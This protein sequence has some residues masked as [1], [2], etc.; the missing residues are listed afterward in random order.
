MSSSEV[1]VFALVFAALGF[2]LYR[3]YIRKDLGRPGSGQNRNAGSS[4]TSHP[5]DDE[6][7]PYAKK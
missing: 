3:K 5:H 7:E 4:F 2:S 1:I 6:Y